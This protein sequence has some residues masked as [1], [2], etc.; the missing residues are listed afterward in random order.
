MSDIRLTPETVAAG[1]VPRSLF[2]LGLALGLTGVALLLPWRVPGLALVAA[3]TT[4]AT[5]AMIVVTVGG[6]RALSRRWQA[7]TLRALFAEA[8]HPVTLTDAMG[9][10]L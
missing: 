3:A 2:L 8:R 5:I 6:R 4:F 1:L 10:V 7:R 9:D